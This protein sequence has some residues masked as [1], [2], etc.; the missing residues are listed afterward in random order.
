M[1]YRAK[2]S[3]YVALLA[4][5]YAGAGLL[6]ADVGITT[7]LDM[8]RYAFM[9]SL[10]ERGSY[11]VDG[12]SFQSIDRIRVG[13]RFYSGKPPLLNFLGAGMYGLLFHALHWS[14][15]TRPE[16][17][18][19]TLIGVFVS[20][21]ICIT[22]VLFFRVLS[23]PFGNVSGQL[24]ALHEHQRIRFA[25]I[26]TVLLAVGSLFPPYTRVFTNHPLAALL[27]LGAFA[28][29]LK[30]WSIRNGL[31]VGIF[32]GFSAAIDLL[33]G[34]FFVLGLGASCLA[35]MKS[36]SVRKD[37]H[38]KFVSGLT[39]GAA[40]PAAVHLFLNWIT[41]GTWLTSYF[42][43]GAFEYPGTAWQEAIN[44]DYDHFP[45]YFSALYHYTL[46]HR[47]S[48]LLVPLAFWGAVHLMHV[49]A[50][51]AARMESRAG[52]SAAVCALVGLVV[53]VPLF[54]VGLA[55][56]SYGNRHL[57]PVL[58]LLYAYLPH[59]WLVGRSL[60]RRAGFAA[61]ALWSTGIGLLGALSPWTQYTMSVYAP[62]DV[63]AE[64]LARQGRSRAAE[65]IVNHTAPNPA[66]GYQELGN[67]H[68][69]Y[70]F[71]VEA[72]ADHQMALKIQPR[73]GPSLFA[74]GFIARQ[75]GNAEVS[76]AMLKRLVDQEPD[77]P[78]AW[79][80]LAKSYELA[81]NAEEAASCRKSAAGLRAAF[82][83]SS[84]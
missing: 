37:S 46:G 80:E 28:T 33:P 13:E 1:S 19:R 25:V 58:P 27:L 59:E 77:N 18:V 57:L 40:I 81:G 3:W 66:M 10:V 29:A 30:P 60:M 79:N 15:S 61:T 55:G 12:S 17:V 73:R 20:L 48:L 2:W 7:G 53:L 9:E 68:W 38:V 31:L 45:G 22:L 75:L 32:A 16:A 36:G 63:A 5:V 47:S 8:D 50:G 83:N 42:V 14:F 51:R 21:P 11:S 84:R 67:R 4:M 64:Q 35:G 34:C 76:V 54:S 6:L 65:W 44:P 56:A 23:R 71:A 39:V 26:A 78:A 72:L 82:G 49:V 62:L 74:G 69:K 41:L 24:E 52:T 43:K 70:G